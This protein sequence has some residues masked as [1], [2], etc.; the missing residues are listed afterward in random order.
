MGGDLFLEA[1]RGG[2]ACVCPQMELTWCQCLNVGVS[3]SFKATLAVYVCMCPKMEPTWWVC[4]C[5]LVSG[6]G[7]PDGSYKPGRGKLRRPGACYGCCLV[8]VP[9][10][11]QLPCCTTPLHACQGSILTYTQDTQ[12]RLSKILLS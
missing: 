3:L 7:E 9:G 4:G 6:G 1:T 12:C 11:C 2:C 10:L 5:W 8:P